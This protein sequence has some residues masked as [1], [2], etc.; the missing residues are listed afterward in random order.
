MKVLLIDNFDSFTFNLYQQISQV[1]QSC[2]S[3]NSKV[4]VV[5]NNEISLESFKNYSPDLVVI[6]PG[7]GDSLAGGFS[8]ELLSLR[9]TKLPILGV[10]LGMQLMAAEFG[11]LIVKAPKPIHGHSWTIKHN[12][13]SI[14]FNVPYST[15]KVARYHSLCVDSE[16]ISRDFKILSTSLDDKILMGIK[17]K[18]LPWI[19]VQ[20]HPESFL[21]EFGDILIENFLKLRI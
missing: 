20:F 13:E 10:C 9:L 1:T 19:G 4:I 12:N 2:F 16:N 11:N 3:T 17:H 18:I 5:R 7:P 15:F 21:T 6:S 8:K 14:F